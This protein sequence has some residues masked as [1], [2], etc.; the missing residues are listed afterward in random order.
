VAER[1]LVGFGAGL[2]HEPGAFGF[3][4]SFHVQSMSS[5]SLEN[6]CCRRS[7]AVTEI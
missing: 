3:E 2:K 7:E 5:A 4:V 1:R 6:P